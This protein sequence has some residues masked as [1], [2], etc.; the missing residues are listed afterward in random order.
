MRES[1]EEK[2]KD[3]PAWVKCPC[4]ENFFCTIH[5][6]HVHDCACPEIDDW[7]VDPYLEGGRPL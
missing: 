7:T 1:P 2:I 3:W 4:C 5:R 6:M